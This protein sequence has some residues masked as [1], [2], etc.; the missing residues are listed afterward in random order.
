M[1]LE[2]EDAELSKLLSEY[3]KSFID[4]DLESL[5]SFYSM[6]NNELIFFDNHKNN[7]TYSVDDHLKLLDDF[8]T[9]GKKTESGKVEEITIENVHHFRTENAACVCFL[10]RY[11]SFPTPAVRSTMYLEKEIAK[12]KI[13]HVH[14]SFE[15]DK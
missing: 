14:C 9:H 15:P 6:N 13:K 12:W 8:F 7:D 11:K 5:K 1:L 10:A 2:N 4:K 3:D